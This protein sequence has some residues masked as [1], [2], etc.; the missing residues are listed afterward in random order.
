MPDIWVT[1][2]T[3]FGHEGILKFESEARPFSSVKEMNDALVDNWNSV[4]KPG[5]KVYHLGDVMFGD[6]EDFAKLWP[7]LH[8]K[9]RLIVGNHDDIKWIAR[10]G[11]FSKVG[12][13]RVF[14]D[15]G[16]LLTHVP[17]NPYG[18]ETGAR[19]DLVNV[20]GHVHTR[21][22]PFPEVRYRNV[23]VEVTNLTPVNIEELRVK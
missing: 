11:F 1:S 22:S 14:T 2:D 8:G 21:G 13:W 6:K 19:K 23:C 4:V 3:H 5:D 18:Y 20:H 16:L 7:K 17:I 12:L 15:M 9:K 10:G